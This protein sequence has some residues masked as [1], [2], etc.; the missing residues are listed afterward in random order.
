MK[1]V[2]L[3]GKRYGRLVVIKLD[4]VQKLPSGKN[5]MFYLCKCDCGKSKV[6]R[7]SSLR[8]GYTQSCGCYMKEMLSK[9]QSVHNMSKSTLYKAWCNMKARCFNTR[10]KDYCDY[11]GRGITMCEEWKDFEVFKEW[12]MKNGFKEEKVKGKN[13]LSLDRVDVNGNYCPDNCRW[14]TDKE[15]ANNKRNTRRFYY[16]GKNLTAREWSDLLGINYGTLV[17]RLHKS[18][19]SVEKAL[20]EPIRKY[21]QNT[22]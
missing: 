17:G 2:N 22:N 8:N 7:A 12:A 18:S 13:I 6:I 9:R 5:E 21:K 19:W 3:S 15:Q 14:A 4:H 11:G 16:K 1:F 20:T 10:R